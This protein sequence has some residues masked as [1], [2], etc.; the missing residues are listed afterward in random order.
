MIYFQF[1]RSNITCPST[2]K[3]RMSTI[4]IGQA[5]LA[6]DDYFYIYTI[7]VYGKKGTATLDCGLVSCLE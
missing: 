4:S 3:D 1:A 6:D 2:Q 7:W 5:V